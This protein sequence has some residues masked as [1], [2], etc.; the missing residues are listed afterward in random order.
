MAEK[1]GA[2]KNSSWKA[3]CTAP[4]FCKTPVGSSTPPI[5]Y[6]VIADLGQS[7]N[8]VPSVRF[9][10][11]PCCVL[12]PS[13]I[14]HCTGDEPGTAKGVRSGTV[15]G[16][17]QPAGASTT[18]RATKKPVVREGDP[19]T[20]NGGNAN[21]L[22]T[23]QPAPGSAAGAG[24]KPTP[25]E[26]A[27]TPD[28]PGEVQ[29]AQEK[30]GIWGM[31]SGSVHFALGAAGF[32][33]GL[34][35]I[36]DLLD[37]GVYALEGDMISA[38][39]S[40][41]AAVP[42]GGDAV[43]AGTL[44][45]KAGK[46]FAREAAERGL[47]KGLEKEG[48]Q[49]LEREAAERLERETARRMEREAL[50]R[51]AEKAAQK[52]VGQETGESAAQG[53]GKAEGGVKVEEK[54]PKRYDK[55]KVIEGGVPGAKYKGGRYGT[56]APGGAARGQ[57]AHHIPAAAAGGGSRSD[58]PAIQMDVSDHRMTASWDNNPGA[59][60]YRS[61]QSALM[62][63]GPKGMLAAMAM[64]ILDIRAKFGNKYDSAIAQTMAWAK[65]KE[66]I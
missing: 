12:N 49:R 66:M 9:N 43:K 4:D 2:R 7:E 55:C 62:S 48:T 10:G 65:C 47:I 57:E 13:I 36:P 45:G 5:P 42:L 14:P 37:A 46:R 33:P 6:Q 29:A 8:C 52:K 32:I 34:G 41:A 1:L 59:A 20:L 63:K 18:V 23:C 38:G 26:P 40:A 17:V 19:C 60:A 54:K 24:G 39:L 28:T 11:D 56:I 51:G 31:V 30:K 64:D 22:Y 44:L 27:I 58:K 15:A 16:E 53:A 25:K 61:R 50:D 21:G 3:I 35:A